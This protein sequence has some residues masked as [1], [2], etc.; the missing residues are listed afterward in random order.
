MLAGG[1][2]EV[3]ARRPPHL[4]PSCLG[5]HVLLSFPVESSARHPVRLHPWFFVLVIYRVRELAP[6]LFLDMEAPSSTYAFSCVAATHHRA[7]GWNG[8]GSS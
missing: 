3:L 5:R 4:T 7:L 8:V 1:R 2:S 6:G